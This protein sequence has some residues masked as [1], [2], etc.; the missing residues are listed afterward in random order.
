MSYF[1]KINGITTALGEQKSVVYNG[2]PLFANATKIY[3]IHKEDSGLPFAF[4]GEYT[5]T[6]T[7]NSLIVQGQTLLASVGTGVDKR[8]TSFATAT[9]ETPEIQAKVKSVKV[10]YDVFPTGITVETN[11]NG[12]GY[13]SQTPIVD[14]INKEVEFNGGLVDGSTTQVR[15]TLAPVSAGSPAVSYQSK[16]KYVKMN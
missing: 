3:S 14:T 7:I 11:V 8:G 13:V 4:M 2:R 5:C 9:I 15:I 12:A 16:I 10:G 6:G 1:G